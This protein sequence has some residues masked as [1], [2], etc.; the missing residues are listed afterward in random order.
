MKASRDQIPGAWRHIMPMKLISGWEVAPQGPHPAA[1]SRHEEAREDPRLEPDLVARI[2]SEATPQGRRHRERH[3]PGRVA[4]STR[5]HQ[6]KPEAAS[7]NASTGQDP[8]Q[9]RPRG[10]T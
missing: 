2:D 9:G 10:P 7:R 4:W 3:R 6:R 1:P 8:E 5:R